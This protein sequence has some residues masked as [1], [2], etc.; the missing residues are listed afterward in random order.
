M[1]KIR[2]SEVR[3][4]VQVQIF[5]LRSDNDDQS[6]ILANDKDDNDMKLE[7]VH[8]SPGT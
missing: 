5:L 8:K 7:V 2:K 1:P 6:R 3:I 4:P